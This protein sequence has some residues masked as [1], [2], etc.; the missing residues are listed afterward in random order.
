MSLHVFYN[1]LLFYILQRFIY[2]WHFFKPGV[3]RMSQAS[4]L[5]YLKMFVIKKILF[6]SKFKAFFRGF[7][8]HT[9]CIGHGRHFPEEIDLNI[10]GKYHLESI[11][12]S[13]LSR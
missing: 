7:Y 4:S 3:L 1:Y 11:D 10:Y 12:L 2:N 5:F 6:V 13:L 9:A 8:F